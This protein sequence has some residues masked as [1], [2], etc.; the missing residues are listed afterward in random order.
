DLTFGPDGN[1]YVS[2][3]YGSSIFR[4]SGE[5][6]AFIDVFVAAHSGGLS[7]PEGLAFAPDGNLYV[8]S[9][10]THSILRY[11]G[12]TGAFVDTFVAPGVNPTTPRFLLFTIEAPSGLTANA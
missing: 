2:S 5:T 4:Y 3:F 6:G 7:Q 10:G 9:I 8:A 12:A 11:N 1:L